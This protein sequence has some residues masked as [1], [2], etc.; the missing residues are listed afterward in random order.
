MSTEFS[1]KI[2]FDS[3]TLKTPYVYFFLV[4]EVTKK[5][6][7]LLKKRKKKLCHSKKEWQPNL[8]MQILMTS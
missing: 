2:I 1:H 4:Q 5:P 6:K 7:L 8:M 3:V